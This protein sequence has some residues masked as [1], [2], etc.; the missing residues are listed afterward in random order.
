MMPISFGLMILIGVFLAWSRNDDVW[1]ESILSG[2]RKWGVLM[3]VVGIIG[4][5]C[6]LTGLPG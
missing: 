3:I 2:E 4:E 5:I 6:V 1:F